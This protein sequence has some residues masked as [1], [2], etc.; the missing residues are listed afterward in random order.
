[1]NPMSKIKQLSLAS[2]ALMD[3]AEG[4][5]RKELKTHQ[6]LR[7]AAVRYAKARM[8]ILVPDKCAACEAMNESDRT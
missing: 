3:A 8:D 6:R 7:E 1:M 4:F 5:K 2:D